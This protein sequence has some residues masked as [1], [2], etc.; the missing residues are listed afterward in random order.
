MHQFAEV[1]AEVTDMGFLRFPLMEPH[2]DVGYFLDTLL[3]RKEPTR[4]PLIEYIINPPNMKRIVEEVLGRTWC[5]FG[6]ERDLQMRYLDNYIEVFYR[7]GFDCVRFEH[8][9]VFKGR[10]TRVGSNGRAWVDDHRGA[11]ASWEDF[12]RYPWPSGK[13]VDL[14]PYEY[15]SKHLPE[16]M[17]IIASSCGGV[18]EAVKNTLMGLETLSYMLYDDPQLV[19]ATFERAGAAIY[20]FYKQLIGLP[21]LVGFCQGDDMGFKTQTLVAPDVLREHVLSWHKKFAQLCH[22]NGLFYFLHSCGNVDAIM[23]DLIEDVRIDGKH[24]FEDAIMPV[25]EFKRKYGD[26]IAVLGGVDVDKLARLSEGDLRAYVRKIIDACAPGGGFAIGSGNSIPDY[27]P[28]ENFLIML[29][30]AL[31]WGAR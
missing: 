28:M 20:E 21:G 2:P 14:F 27:V 9:V 5:P 24:S 31:A 26:R 8:G 7:L 4:I 22:E 25:W 15:I 30:E 10:Q 12:E 18:F 29:D 19:S 17:G 16:G 1:D 3:Q 13:D 11:I 23:E 6:P